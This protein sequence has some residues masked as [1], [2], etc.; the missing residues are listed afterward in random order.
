MPALRKL[1]GYAS[2]QHHLP[3]M[4][5]AILDEM[6]LDP[7]PE[8][9]RVVVHLEDGRLLASSTGSQRSRCV[10]REASA[11]QDLNADSTDLPCSGMHSMATANGLVC[12]PALQEGGPTTLEKGSL[13]EVI[14]LGPI[15]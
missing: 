15:V 13:A 4:K 5:A 12:V 3:K 1:S 8:F 6:R 9:H 11:F 10:E 14:L 2:G 7:R